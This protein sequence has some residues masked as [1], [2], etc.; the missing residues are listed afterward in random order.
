MTNQVMCQSMESDV[1][2]SL[3]FGDTYISPSP[4]AHTLWNVHYL[5]QLVHPLKTPQ[6]TKTFKPRCENDK[7]STTSKLGSCMSK[8]RRRSHLSPSHL[9]PATLHIQATTMVKRTT[10]F[11]YPFPCHPISLKIFEANSPRP[12]TNK[13]LGHY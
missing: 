8:L 9:Q 11:I 2:M 13:A 1:T 4:L 7:L 5:P 12:S 6:R 10:I 3:Q